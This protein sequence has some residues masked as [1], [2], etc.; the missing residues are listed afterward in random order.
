MTRGKILT[1]PG[2]EQ[3]AKRILRAVRLYMP[4]AEPRAQGPR[5]RPFVADRLRRAYRKVTR[6]R[7]QPHTLT[8]E[9]FHDLRRFCR[10]A[11]YMA[12][13]LAL[14]SGPGVRKMARRLERIC[15]ALG[16]LHD[17][18]V[19][20]ERLTEKQVRN[21]PSLRQMLTEERA[22]ALMDFR[23]AW[24]KLCRRTVRVR[25]LAERDAVRKEAP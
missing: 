25:C 20:I 9:A 10:R 7:I 5:F 6:T 8:P 4:A 23:T 18:D 12:E 15:D 1:G 24:E 19:A 11:R 13:F 3:T 17:A 21:L 2:W 22:K 14:V 16:R